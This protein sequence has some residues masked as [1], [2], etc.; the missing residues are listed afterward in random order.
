MWAQVAIRVVPNM[1]VYCT[2]QTGSLKNVGG[3]NF[4]WGGGGHVPPVPPP[5]FPTPMY[6]Y[7]SVYSSGSGL[8]RLRI[9]S[10]YN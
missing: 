8:A 10:C 4:F 1:D 2:Y 5:P 7:T 9:Y 6:V 3:C